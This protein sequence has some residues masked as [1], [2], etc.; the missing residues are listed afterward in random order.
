MNTSESSLSTQADLFEGE[1]AD[2]SEAEADEPSSAADSLYQYSSS[3]SFWWQMA[4]Q[5]HCALSKPETA[6]YIAIFF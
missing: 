4:I 2:S 5:K 3:W 1:D 6:I